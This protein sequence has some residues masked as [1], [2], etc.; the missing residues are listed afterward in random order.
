MKYLDIK[1]ITIAHYSVDVPWQFLNNWL[2]KDLPKGGV[3]LNPDFQ[4]DY[5]WTRQ[6]KIDYIEWIMRG[7]RSGRDIYFNC[8]GWMHSFKGPMVIVDGKQRL[9]TALEFLDNKIKVYGHYLNEYED[10]D[11]LL[12]SITL[13]FKFHINDLDNRED[14][15][16]WYIDMNTG[17]TIHTTKEIENVKKLLELERKNK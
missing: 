8:P 11:V 4:R 9:N 15:L 10:K 3:D 7:G 12:R 13:D 16:Q 14:V 2:N 5:I 6:Q 17:G 1:Q